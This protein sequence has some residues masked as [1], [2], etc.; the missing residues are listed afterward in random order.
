MSLRNSKLPR[1]AKLFIVRS[2]ARRERH[3][4]IVEQLR[5]QFEVTVDRR[6]LHHYNP[7]HNPKLDDELKSLYEQTRADYWREV[8]LAVDARMERR[9]RERDAEREARHAPM[10]GAG[11]SQ[12]SDSA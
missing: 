3:A 7:K 2:L 8:E 11:P 5:E 9:C 4:V 10:C 6:T 1:D 12:S